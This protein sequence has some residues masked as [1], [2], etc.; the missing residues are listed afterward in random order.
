MIPDVPQSVNYQ[1]LQRTIDRCIGKFG[2]AH[3]MLILN[4]AVNGKSKLQNWIPTDK[5]LIQFI[6]QHCCSAFNVDYE[7]FGKSASLRHRDCK[8]IAVHLARKH[9]EMTYGPLVKCFGLTKHQ[10][11]YA[12]LTCDE[13]LEAP[14]TYTAFN[15][16]YNDI[17]HQLLNFISQ[18]QA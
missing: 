7:D 12:C 15:R 18:L 14:Y 4:S 16:S 5:L 10:V 6:K 11:V 2:I 8:Y 1:D 13:R 17:E 3:T 9:L